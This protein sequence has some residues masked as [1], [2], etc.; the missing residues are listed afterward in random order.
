MIMDELKTTRG[1]QARGRARR[2]K[3]LLAATQLL[4][5]QPIE[6]ITFN[7]VAS[8]AK[9]P[10]GSAYHFYSSIDDVYAALVQ[11]LGDEL[12]EYLAS[13]LAPE[14]V[15]RW[16]DVVDL[17][18]ERSVEFYQAHVEAQQLLIG[19]KT[20]LHLKHIDRD[21]DQKIAQVFWSHLQSHF[22][23]NDSDFDFDIFFYTVEII[24]LLLSLSM[25]RYDR[26]TEEMKREAKHAGIGYLRTHLPKVFERS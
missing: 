7:D 8:L 22:K 6:T 24:D 5:S 4:Q 11:K 25:M 1:T 2:E 14:S 12:L 20:P 16:E 3:L 17:M 26:I 10:K 18:C 21:N 13:P 9:V 19:N 15:Q 23:I